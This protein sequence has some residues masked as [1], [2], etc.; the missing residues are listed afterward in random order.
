M[1]VPLHAVQWAGRPFPADKAPYAEPVHFFLP[2]QILEVEHNDKAKL[3]AKTLENLV[4]I[5]AERC[6][7]RETYSLSATKHKT[8]VGSAGDRAPAVIYGCADREV[9][10][11]LCL[12]D[13]A[14]TLPRQVEAWMNSFFPGAGIDIQPVK[15]ASMVTLGLRTNPSSDFQ[16]PQNVGYGL[17]HILP[18]ITACLVAEAGELILIENPEVHLHPAGQS[19]M[20]TFL[21][22][23]A[24]RGVQVL[25]ETHSDHVLNGVRRAVR[26][27]VIEPNQVQ[28]HFF[29]PRSQNV[30]ANPQVTAIAI[31]QKGGLDAW[32]AGFFDQI[33][34]DL[35]FLTGWYA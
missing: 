13:I 15:N 17:S 2:T 34:K 11:A 35:S 21:T 10:S 29:K 25:L 20:G 27:M 19:L 5:S 22:K 16:R 7:P 1:S 18:I 23:I 33:D 24:A 28:I 31:D 30:E 9:D 6:G 12:G 3:L 4:Y 14:P 32:P 26:D 8:D